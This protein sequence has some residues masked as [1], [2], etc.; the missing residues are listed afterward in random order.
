[1]TL[2]D[3]LGHQLSGVSNQRR[4]WIPD[5]SRLIADSHETIEK[6]SATAGK[7]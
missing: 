6:Y 7:E 5:S 1:M 3:H 4:F 2:P